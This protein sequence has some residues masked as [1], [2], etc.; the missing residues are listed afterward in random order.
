MIFF[1]GHINQILVCLILA[2]LFLYFE[3]DL[4]TQSGYY[5]QETPKHYSQV[6]I[7]TVL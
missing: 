4:K 3:D 1:N 5:K 2:F 6:E 7:Y